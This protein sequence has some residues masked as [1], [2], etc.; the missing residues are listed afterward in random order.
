[1]RRQHG[2]LLL[3]WP[4]FEE[5][6]LSARDPNSNNNAVVCPRYN[7]GVNS[8]ASLCTHEIALL[9]FEHK[10]FTLLTSFKHMLFTLLLRLQ[11]TQS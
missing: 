4:Y 5:T 10:L 3:A 1:M 6:H 9:S 8:V 11:Q 2:P 7:R